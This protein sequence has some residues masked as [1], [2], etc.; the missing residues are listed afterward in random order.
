MLPA[1]QGEFKVVMEPEIRFNDGGKPW[2]KLRCKAADRV[3]DAGG[4]W[5]DGDACFIDVT[6]GA[7]VG[8][9]RIVESIVKDDWVVVTGRLRQREWD[10]NGEKRVS[11]SISADSIGVSTRFDVARSRKSIESGASVASV[12][13]VLGGTVIQDDAPP[14]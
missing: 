2:A 5:V 9:E 3:K 8:A 13:E 6:V 11:Y 12:Q 10:H 14:F 1:V 7:A 4:K